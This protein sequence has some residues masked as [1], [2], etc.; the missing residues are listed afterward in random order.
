MSKNACCQRAFFKTSYASGSVSFAPRFTIFPLN[1]Q[2]HSRLSWVRWGL[3]PPCPSALP[4]WPPSAF[5]VAMWHVQTWEPVSSTC[6]LLVFVSKL[7]PRMCLSF[8]P[9]FHK[10][11]GQ[12]FSYLLYRALGIPRRC[13][14]GFK[15]N[16]REGIFFYIIFH[17]IKGCLC[18]NK[19]MLGN[20]W[21]KL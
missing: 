11:V 10:T 7:I 17:L 16:D 5:T 15:A 20:S 13:P 6:Y 14:F 19:S 4:Q 21:R 2:S 18:L 1:L 12:W 3:Q 8:L 9:I